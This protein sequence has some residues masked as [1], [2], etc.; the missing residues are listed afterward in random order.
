MIVC[1][2]FPPTKLSLQN[3]RFIIKKCHDEKLSNFQKE[4]II[5]S[6]PS[7]QFELRQRIKKEILPSIRKYE[8]E[9]WQIYS[10][11]DF[12]FSEEESQKQLSEIEESIYVWPHL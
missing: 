8:S 11:E 10:K 6:N 12:Y 2:Y 4:L 9:Y 1:G 7:I 3:I 5:S